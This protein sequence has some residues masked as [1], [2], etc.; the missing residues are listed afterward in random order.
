MSWVERNEMTDFAYGDDS[1]ELLCHDDIG[2]VKRVTE[3]A[4][5]G[6]KS[7]QSPW[8]PAS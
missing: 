7:S 2:L 3:V 1:L 6:A 4:A 5:L 8:C